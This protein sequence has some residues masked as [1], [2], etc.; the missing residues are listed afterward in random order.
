MRYIDLEIKMDLAGKATAANQAKVRKI[1]RREFEKR[2]TKMIAEF[3]SHPVTMEING[4]I[5]SSNISGTLDGVTN[6]YSFIGFPA[7]TD[8]ID[9]ILDV[10]RKDTQIKYI[11]IRKN[12]TSFSINIPDPQDVFEVT[13]MP[14]ALG[15]SW[16]KGIESGISGLGWYLGKESKSS[17]SGYGLQSKKR[18]PERPGLKFKNT[19]YISNFLREQRNEFQR[20]FYIYI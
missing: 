6:L 1:I 18:L 9:P 17:R 13:P 10:I 16:A 15:R 4:G 5:D 12:T 8:P 2:K 19:K 20:N 7:G 14:W 3:L 11:K